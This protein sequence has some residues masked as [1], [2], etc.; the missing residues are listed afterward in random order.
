MDKELVLSGP[1]PSVKESLAY[2]PSTEA[3]TGLL[4]CYQI[5]RRHF[6]V[7]Q[8]IARAAV[9]TQSPRPIA[10][11]PVGEPVLGVWVHVVGDDFESC[12][13]DGDNE[14]RW[15]ATTDGRVLPPPDGWFPLPVVAGSSEVAGGES[16][17]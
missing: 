3:Q 10:E 2:D 14:N 8:A 16:D 15:T 1:L 11:A 9:A 17:D 12:Y 4:K 6:L 5:L 7:V 13:I